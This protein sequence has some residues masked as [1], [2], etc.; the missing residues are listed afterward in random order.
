MIKKLGLR[1][2]SGLMFLVLGCMIFASNDV[3]A[4]TLPIGQGDPVVFGQEVTMPEAYKDYYYTLTAPSSGD[5]K[6]TNTGEFNI[7]ELEINDANNKRVAG[8]NYLDAGRSYSFYLRQ[9]QYSVRVK[10][11]NH[12]GSKFTFYFTSVNESFAENESVN[13]DSDASPA[14]IETLNDATLTGLFSANDTKDW[15]SFKLDKKS[16][17]DFCLTEKS[18]SINE[19]LNYKLVDENGDTIS[20]ITY[21]NENEVR[22]SLALNP[23]TYKLCI[24]TNRDDCVGIYNFRLKET[25]FD[26]A[27]KAVVGKAPTVKVKK[28]GKLA[29]A[30]KKFAKADGYQIQIAVKKNFKGATATATKKDTVK[31]TVTVKKAL[32]GKTAYVRVRTYKLSPTGEK[33]WSSWSKVKAVKT[34]K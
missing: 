8:G 4:D 20:E 14:S 17:V 15:Y 23:G 11:M 1:M 7:W 32:R 16:I 3:K 29:V 30:W 33:I 19:H 5:L 2:L 10:T 18:S 22:L 31:K 28:G 9:G 26:I 12:N 25:V 6:F 24:L 13:N 21:K 27:A 34:K